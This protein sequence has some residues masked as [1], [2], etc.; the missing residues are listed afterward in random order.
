MKR[1]RRLEGATASGC[2]GLAHSYV[3]PLVESI[4]NLSSS[5]G[6]N[7][8][9]LTGELQVSEAAEVLANDM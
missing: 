9:T 3:D 6:L 4:F 5:S 7:A 1:T 2:G 8:V